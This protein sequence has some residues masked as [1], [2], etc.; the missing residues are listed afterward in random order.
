[1][2][3]AKLAKE[4]MYGRMACGRPFV[5]CLA[6]EKYMIEGADKAFLVAVPDKSVEV[7]K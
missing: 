1:M 2:P 7:L 3:E 4:K 5:V 6:S